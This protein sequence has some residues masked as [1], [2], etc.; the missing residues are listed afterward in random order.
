MAPSAA[1][2]RRPRADRRAG[3]CRTC[4]GRDPVVAEAAFR[5]RLAQ[6]GATLLEPYKN[7]LYSHQVRCAAG[8]LCTPRPNSVHGYEEVLRL[9]IGLPGIVAPEME[10]AARAALALAGVIPL[11]GREHYDISALASA[12]DLRSSRNRA[13]TSYP[14]STQ[15][16][17]VVL[18]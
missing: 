6:L 8:R 16:A 17:G 1:A 15:M 10:S 11:Q 2:A 18:T 5:A 4:A 13:T 7:A 14:R 12:G 9:M 3:I